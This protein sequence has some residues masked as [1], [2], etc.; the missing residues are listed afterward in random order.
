MICLRMGANGE[1]QGKG[2]FSFMK[3][4]NFITFFSNYSLLKTDFV[5]QR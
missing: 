5:I 4:G 2:V 1:L 3:Y